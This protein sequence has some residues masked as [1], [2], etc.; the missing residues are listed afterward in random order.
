VGLVQVTPPAEEPVALATV[1]AFGRIEENDDDALLALL[2]ASAREVLEELTWRAL[3]TQSWRYTADGFPP[4]RQSILLPRPALL[5]VESVEWLDDAGAVQIMDPAQWEVDVSASDQG[6]VRP[7]PG[8]SW[9]PAALRFEAARVTFTAG[10]GGQ[11][12]QP[13]RVK[14]ACAQLVLAAYDFREPLTVG[15]VAKVPGLDRVIQSLSA[16]SFGR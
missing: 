3:V 12:A 7:L 14:V 9:P 5:S 2:I 13:A 8:A 15:T 11:D 4:G 10:Y 6:R 16:R 1:K